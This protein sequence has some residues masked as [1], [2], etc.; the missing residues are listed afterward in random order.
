[1]FSFVLF[2]SQAHF[3]QHLFMEANNK[4]PGQTAPRQS[5]LCPYCLQL[6][7]CKKISRQESRW[8]NFRGDEFN[9]L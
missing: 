4:N 6:G 8:H 5:D 2:V 7:M 9:K 1:M 3:R